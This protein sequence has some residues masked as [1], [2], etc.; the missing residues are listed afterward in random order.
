RVGADLLYETTID[1]FD[2]ALGTE[3]EVP[4]LE[5]GR[6]IINIPPGVQFGSQFRLRGKGLP[7]INNGGRGDLIVKVNIEIPKKLSERERELLV[8]IASLRGKNIPKNGK[9][10][11]EKVKNAFGG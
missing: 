8:E 5:K 6:E 11:F 3:I 4:T 9:S 10:F 2:A 1:M 7:Y